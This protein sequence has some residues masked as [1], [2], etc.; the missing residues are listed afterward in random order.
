MARLL[1]GFD[2][3]GRRQ[4]K[5]ERRLGTTGNTG[6]V[7]AHHRLRR[8]LGR[9]SAGYRR[10]L[11]DSRAGQP[12]PDHFHQR[13]R[14]RVLCSLPA[15]QRSGG[16]RSHRYRLVVPPFDR[17]VDGPACRLG[18]VVQVAVDVDRAHRYRGEGPRAAR[19][20]PGA[21]R[22]GRTRSRCARS[23]SRS[24]ARASRGFPPVGARSPSSARFRRCPVWLRRLPLFRGRCPGGDQRRTEALAGNG[25]SSRLVRVDDA[26]CQLRQLG[27]VVDPTVARLVGQGVVA[28]FGQAPV[29]AEP[30]PGGTASTRR[31]SATP[32]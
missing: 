27:A 17:H 1:T 4:R 31:S 30:T 12:L 6:D 20:R 10:S 26:D 16:D 22:T 13:F 21:G 2:V 3:E 25:S 7:V 11:F 15:P 24:S 19:G 8:C 29:S 23:G 9:D 28:D 5:A 14:V 32:I 18:P